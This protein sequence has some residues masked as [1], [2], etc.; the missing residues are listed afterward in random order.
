MFAQQ[1]NQVRSSSHRMRIALL[2]GCLIPA[3]IVPCIVYFIIATRTCEGSPEFTEPSKSL[4]SQAY[5]MPVIINVPAAKPI[6]RISEISVIHDEHSIDINPVYVPK[7]AEETQTAPSENDNSQNAGFSFTNEGHTI[8]EVVTSSSSSLDITIPV[9]GAF[10][11]EVAVGLNVFGV[12]ASTTTRPSAG[13][14]L[15]NSDYSKHYFPI[16]A[17]LSFRHSFSR[18]WSVVSGLEMSLY[19]SEIKSEVLSATSQT[20]CFL[21]VPIRFDYHLLDLGRISVFAGLGMKSDWCVRYSFYGIAANAVDYRPSISALVTGA[22]QYSITPRM[23]FY[24]EPT[25]SRLITSSG[26]NGIMTYRE[27]DPFLFSTS[28]GIRIDI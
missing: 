10:V 7:Q 9:I 17:G 20:A 3:V 6:D 28:I 16:I 11:N 4:V 23:S 12:N 18:K 19:F 8:D 2:W 24:V 21:G 5:S 27:Q 26:T 15:A 22:I 25:L 14:S 13:L 1:L